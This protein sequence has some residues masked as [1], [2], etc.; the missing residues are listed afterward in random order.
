MSARLEQLKHQKSLLEEHLQWL[1]Q[2]IARENG[3]SRI[4]AT[5]QPGP[6]ESENPVNPQPVLQSPANNPAAG[7]HPT[8]AREE[9]A[10][11]LSEQ[12]I[13]Q[14]GNVSSRREM[15]PRLGLV[16]FFGGILG[17]LALIIFL[18]YWFG[19]R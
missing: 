10:E 16:L 17:I 8:E 5:P 3:S 15:D 2:E 6:P 19:Y 12:L 7:T 13:S 18:I 4:S 1:D 11:V 14:Y 9:E